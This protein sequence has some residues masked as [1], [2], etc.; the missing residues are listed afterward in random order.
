MRQLTM[1]PGRDRKD[2]SAGTS[3]A[4]GTAPSGHGCG[5]KRSPH[6][7]TTD[8]RTPWVRRRNQEKNRVGE[9]VLGQLGSP[10][11]KKKPHAHNTRAAQA[12]LWQSFFIL[13]TWDIKRFF[14]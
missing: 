6:S 8:R 5:S 12:L 14:F 10:K 11:E 13:G 1:A 7:G 9:S 3:R 2:A 4:C